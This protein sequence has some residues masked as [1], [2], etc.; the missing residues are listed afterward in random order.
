MNE[1]D[2]ILELVKKGIISTEEGLSLLEKLGGEEKSV[3]KKEV[4][5]EKAPI[6]HLIPELNPENSVVKEEAAEKVVVEA[7]EELEEVENQIEEDGFEDFSDENSEFDAQFKQ[8]MKQTKET[9]K[10]ASKQ[11]K[12]YA[13]N[14]GQVLSDAFGTVRTTLQENID[15][16][17]MNVK[18][19]KVASTTFKHE[20]EY[21]E[22]KATI[23]DIQNTNG[24]VKLKSSTEDKVVIK[25][26]VKI[27]GGISEETPLEE[28]NKRSEFNITDE[29]IEV[30]IPSKFIR[31]ELTVELPER[32]YDHISIKT[33]N[34]KV[35]VAEITAGDI[36]VNST[37]GEIN[38]HPKKAS[39]IE[40]KGVNGN[41]SVRDTELID[42][43]INTINGDVLVT[44]SSN[45]IAVS[46]VNGS[47][48]LTL[49]NDTL[50]K[51]NLS[52]VNGTIKAA[53]PKG[54][55]L[56]GNVSTTFGKVNQR[57]EE[58]EMI[59]ATQKTMQIVR[60]GEQVVNF[61]IR[62]TTGSVYLKD[63]EN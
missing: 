48:R 28:F 31:A 3:E 2:R 10:E 63:A 61:D 52:N 1:K 54:S 39:M 60:S 49:N 15:W 20:F 19:P 12:P 5:E 30:K 14:I 4:V 36:Y 16:K 42:T 27:Y 43:L 44:A 58:I 47:M 37:N 38:M 56:D 50:T 7:E 51:L 17:E 59:N 29:K 6:I 21:P 35:E 33:M 25:A 23:I 34:G 55:G 9:L 40:I 8:A 57:L 46:L 32:L 22:N 41:I 26:D 11:I 18:V 45:A 13:T 53:F 62:T 24:A